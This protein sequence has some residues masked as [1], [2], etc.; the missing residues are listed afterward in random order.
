MKRIIMLTLL[1][2]ALPAEAELYKWTDAQGR[3]HFTDRKPA[4]GGK[5]ETLKT[6]QARN[7]GGREA[8]AAT[9]SPQD[10]KS[11]LDR[12]KRMADILA[13]ERE[14]QEAAIASKKKEEAERLKKCH[15]ARDYRKNAQGSRLYDIDQKG[16]RV[17]M[18]DKAYDAHMRDLDKAIKEFCK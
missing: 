10:Q 11:L 6:P 9:A 7:P 4:D 14:Q 2:A 17:Y 8:A 13:Q 3:V 16:E 18:D 5:V 1:L 12:Q 15:E